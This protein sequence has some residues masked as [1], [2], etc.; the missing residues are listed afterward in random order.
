MYVKIETDRLN[1]LRQNQ[2]KIR[3]ELYQGIQDAIFH[4]DND[5][6]RVGRKMILPATFVGSPRDMYQRYQDAMALVRIGKPD[7]FITMT[8]NPKWPEIQT[9]LF[10]GQKATDRPDI[11]GKC[12]KFIINSVFEKR[13]GMCICI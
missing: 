5:S 9:L 10:S 13:F 6:R 12:I 7:L 2:T 1:F 3:C 8:C 4:G 11:T